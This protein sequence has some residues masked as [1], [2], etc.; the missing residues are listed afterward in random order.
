MSAVDDNHLLRRKIMG[1][2]VSQAIFAVTEL[3][4]AE[5]LR[6]G[7]IPVDELAERTGAD[8]DA[9]HRFMRV[10]AAEGLFV[11]HPGGSFSGTPMSALLL[12]DAPGSL[13]HLVTLMSGEAYQV[14]GGAGHSL[15]TG[16]SAFEQVYGKPMFEWLAGDPAASAA[17][18]EAQAGL[19]E[20][21]LLP[22]LELDWSAG[23]T[24]VD[25]GGGNGGLLNLLLGRNPHLRGVLFDLPHVV[26]D[27]ELAPGVRERCTVVGGDFFSSV[28][29]GGQTYVLAQILH[30]WDD[31]E[32]RTILRRC[33]QAMGPG[34]RLLILEQVVPDDSEPHPAKLLDLHMLVLLGG[35]E[36][37]QD[38]WQRL[39]TESGFDLLSV[40]RSARSAII[41][42]RPAAA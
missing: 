7:P 5:Q 10:L 41:E 28:P 37:G 33:R 17:F 26:R 40:D 4:V 27:D 18:N 39:L 16:D 11:E 38:A 3:D 8:A 1:Y 19:V 14:W 20:L 15:R 30:D 9:L 21:R 13:R 36:R 29:D 6:N 25:V 34:A 42:A 24:V 22:L 12:R 35:R 23:T 31:D 2:I 32:A